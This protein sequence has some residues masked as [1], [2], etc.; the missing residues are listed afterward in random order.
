MKNDFT[1]ITYYDL[2][3]ITES[4]LPK[5]LINIIILLINQIYNY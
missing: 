4:Y 2:N 1:R 5:N 3:N